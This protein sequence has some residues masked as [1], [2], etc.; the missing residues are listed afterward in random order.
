MAYPDGLGEG[1]DGNRRHYY[2]HMMP[3][4]Q[5]V[6]DRWLV[7]HG[8]QVERVWYD[9]HVGLAVQVPND[10]RPEM[11]RVSQ[12]VTRKRIDAVALMGGVYHV[13]EVKPWG[14]YVALGQAL[15]YWR[16]FRVEVPGAAPTLAVVVCAKADPDCL[17]DYQ[18]HDVGLWI[19][20]HG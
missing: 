5:I 7:G 17:D 19:V 12:A 1:F 6:W 10:L 11:L 20:G 13:I 2:P 15:V 8:A 9:V 16:L 18:E 3:E 4:D 14:G